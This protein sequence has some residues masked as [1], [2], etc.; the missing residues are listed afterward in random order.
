MYAAF[1]SHLDLLPHR[2]QWRGGP[3]Q[4]LSPSSWFPR[5]QCAVSTWK[6]GAHNAVEEQTGCETLGASPTPH[7]RERTSAASKEKK[8][9]FP[10]SV[11][12]TRRPSFPLQPLLTK[13]NSLVDQHQ[14]SCKLYPS[15]FLKSTTK[16][17]LNAAVEHTAQ[18]CVVT[19]NAC[20]SGAP[21]RC[22]HRATASPQIYPLVGILRRF[23]QFSFEE[24]SSF[25][26]FA[27]RK[28]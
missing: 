10:W 19:I 14:S 7:T 18:R 3:D 12:M 9:K 28:L 11:S 22:G 1:H 6:S 16:H 5:S 4:T 27:L 13:F 8:R 23:G 21:R 17:S 15:F 26:K 25:S 24:R 20:G 2:T